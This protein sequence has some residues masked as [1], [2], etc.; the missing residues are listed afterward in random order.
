MWLES[1]DGSEINIYAL[2]QRASIIFI[3]IIFAFWQ[4]LYFMV[5]LYSYFE[6]SSTCIFD[7]IIPTQR[8]MTMTCSTRPSPDNNVVENCFW[9]WVTTRISL[10]GWAGYVPSNEK[11]GVETSHPH[12][13]DVGKSCFLVRPGVNHLDDSQENERHTIFTNV[14]I[15]QHTRTNKATSF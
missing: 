14:F 15:K 1:I 7:N 3:F 8:D 6:L 11:N 9:S 4:V 5:T 13:F 2:R 12:F 10:L